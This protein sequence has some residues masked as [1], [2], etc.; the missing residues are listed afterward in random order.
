M[1]ALV[2]L[3]IVTALVTSCSSNKQQEGGLPVIDVSKNYP[4]KE[5]LLTDIA[6]VTCLYLNSDDEDYL[7]RG[8]VNYITDNTIVVV[9]RSS[10]SILLFSKDGTPKSRFN[11]KGQGPE[12]YIRVIGFQGEIVYNEKAD[13]VFVKDRSK[14]QVYSSSG[15]YKRTITLPPDIRYTNEIIDFDDHSLFFCDTSIEGEIIATLSAGGDL[16]AKNY[17]LP[18]YRISKTTGEV[19]DY[20]ELQGT[21]LFLGA[22]YEGRYTGG[23]KVFMLGDRK[24]TEKC[25]E[26]ILLF[27]AHTDTVFLYH[28]DKSLTPYLSKTPLVASLNPKEYLYHCLDRGQYQFT[29]VKIM[30]EGVYPV[31]YPSEYYM[32]NKKTGEIVRQKLLLPDYKDKEFI[33]DPSRTYAPDEV[34]SD[35]I[36]SDGMFYDGGYCFELGL[37]DLKEAYRAGKLSGQL[38]DLVATLDEDRDNNVFMLVEFK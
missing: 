21:D 17:V 5:I 30:H 36:V 11:H 23:M 2:K 27:N 34:V 3:A 4:E 8:S 31:F 35:E 6:D 24:Y 29:Q 15:E 9:D 19:L 16:S 12:E 22:Y 18:F 32:R 28:G 25:P 37:Y 1:K 38:K 7:Y 14:I 33:M 20:I 13:E 10:G 26:G